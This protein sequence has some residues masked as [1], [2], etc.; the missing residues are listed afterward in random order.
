M[1]FW[2]SNFLVILFLI[3]VGVIFFP[4]FQGKLPVPADDLVGLYHPWRDSFR[5]EFPNGY[6]YKNPLITDPV[7][8]QIPYRKLATDLLK[9][10][11][12]PKWNPYSFAGT[13]LLANIQT[14]TFYPLNLFFW[15][16]P[17]IE[18]WTLLVILQPVLAFVF[19]YLYL[20]NLKLHPAAA[21]IG[22]VSFAFSG[23][24]V[25]WLSW[26]TLGHV[27]LWLP[28]I[29]MATDKL[30]EQ[31]NLKWAIILTF[32]EISMILGGHWQPTLY[33]LIF[34]IIYL[35]VKIWQKANK[36]WQ[37]FFRKNLLFIFTLGIVLLLTS[38]QWL[39]SIGFI[40]SS[41]R[42]FDLPPN[43]KLEWFLPYKHLVQFVAPDFFGNPATGNYFG[44]WNYGEFIGYIGLIPLLFGVIAVLC[45]RDK[46]TVFYTAVTLISL[47]LVLPTPLAQIPYILNLPLI[48]TLQPTRII[49]LICFSL[50]ILAALGL[51]YFLK[52][53]VR[54]KL[55]PVIL[56][57]SSFITLGWLVPAFIKDPSIGP[58]Q[59][60]V[61]QRN[62]LMPTFLFS[63]FA[64][65]TIASF[66]KPKLKNLSL[67]LLLLITLFDLYRFTTKFIPFT[68]SSLFFPQTEAIKYLQ[69][70]LGYY[71]LMSA[72]R[73]ILPPNTSVYFKLASVDGYDPLYLLNYGQV[74]A[75]WTR[76]AA[77]IS[78]ATFHRI[79]TPEIP[80]W[81]TDLLGV[82]FVL[83]FEKLPEPQ[84]KLVFE[85]GDTKIYE[86]TQVF[87]RVFLVEEVKSLPSRQ[88]VVDQMFADP[89]SLMRI[90]YIHQPLSVKPQPLNVDEI[91]KIDNYSEN[92]ITLSANVTTE[93]ML[94]LT[95]I[96]YE[97]WRVFIDDKE[98]F[99]FPVDLALRGVVVPRG[100]H[101]IIFKI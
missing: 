32:A 83:S 60:A 77:D 71:R 37:I 7:R 84:F 65:G 20:R 21:F 70:N 55:W 45:R 100:K 94:V 1:K 97:A 62:L 38:I 56:I 30:I 76:T 69:Q 49:V 44:L 36:N 80:H 11:Q 8:Q 47:M 23:F 14:A 18:G 16:L 52:F 2:K 28:L 9:Q 89:R 27:V 54:Q 99:I 63:V 72:D 22:G 64:L 59:L 58:V 15:L 81:W 26:N 51:D 46:K 29:L 78:P 86:N 13:P 35:W 48:S 90:A 25:A 19:T 42:E 101:Q 95:D 12:I 93:R 31:F 50:A 87:P 85:E 96:Y 6:P 92:E 43:L 39:P 24:M 41:A 67:C 17:F 3:F 57:G 82:K 73:R 5:K 33:V 88:A 53:Q 61:M 4:V 34:T 75:S 10:G 79:I 74:A 40:L 68:S 91:V 66:Y 98:S